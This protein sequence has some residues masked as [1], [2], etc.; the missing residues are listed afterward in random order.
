[1][2]LIKS[3]VSGAIIVTVIVLIR[4]AALHRLPKRVFRILWGIALMRLLLPCSLPVILPAQT[5]R[6]PQ[7]P[8]E[9]GAVTEVLAA[10][11]PDLRRFAPSPTGAWRI[12]W[13][14]GLTF[15][16]AFFAVVYTRCRRTF[17]M[18]LPVRDERP[19][20]WLAQ[21]RLR[22][23]VSVRQS[24]RVTS[25]LTF[26]ILH[27]VILFP[28]TFDWTDTEAARCV[29]AHELVHIRR[30]DAAGKFLL[31]AA[32]CIHWFNP[33]VWVLY[34]LANRDMELSCDEAVVLRFGERAA[35]AN[36]LIRMEER[37]SGLIPLCSG[38]SRN[39]TEERITAIMKTKK[40]TTL[41]VLGAAVLVA[42]A[43]ALFAV[44]AMEPPS[45]R[46][47]GEPELPEYEISDYESDDEEMLTSILP[48]LEESET[49]LEPYIP[50]NVT[51]ERVSPDGQI[52][53]YYQGQSVHSLYDAETGVWVANS[54][55]GMYL[56]EDTVDLEAVYEDGEL[57]GVTASPCT[58]REPLITTE[59]IRG[60]AAE[61]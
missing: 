25:P 26:G 6:A 15:S 56:N 48:E 49:G 23:T 13:L 28:K 3:S 41:T 42:G 60:T 54:M 19:L 21:D 27:P 30:F 55:R 4:A 22:R 11:Q 38:F 8:M 9:T 16:A 12:V 46:T 35:Y 47:D 37:K 18:S 58:H 20:R 57:T 40:T 17:R 61:Q 31:T 10:A 53:I 44:S 1:M 50:F 7:P 52:R 2:N 34:I 32:L 33:F 43:A 59:V 45:A 39:A 5:F 36:V 29:L 24:D 51:W 14:T